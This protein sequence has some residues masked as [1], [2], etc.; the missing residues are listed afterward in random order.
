MRNYEKL[1]IAIIGAGSVSFCPSTVLDIFKSKEINTL[2]LE[3]ALMDI[4][5]EALDVSFDF[6]QKLRDQKNPQAKISATTNLKEALQDADFVVTAIEKD[7]YHYWSQDFHIPRRYGFRQIYGENG[8]PGGLFH[9]LRNLGPMLEIAHAMEEVCPDA[10]LLNYTNPEAKLVEIILKSTKIKA[11]GLCHGEWW[12]VWQVAHILGMKME[13]IETEACGLNHFACLTKIVDKKTGKDLY[14]LLKEK[15]KQ[16]PK[17]ANWDHDALSRLM[18]RVYGVW[19]YPGANHIGEYFA[20]S[21][22]FL[23]SA[24]MQFFYDP[25]TENPWDN[26]NNPLELVYTVDS[27]VNRD[28]ETD[29]AQK[30]AK[31]IFESAFTWNDT[32]ES[33]D[34]VQSSE[35]GVPIIE[36][37]VFNKTTKIGAVNVLNDGYAPNLPNGMAVEIPAIVDG[38]GIHPQ[39]TAKIPTALAAMIAT[40]GAVTELLHEAYNEKSRNK[41]LQAVLL[42]PTVSSYNNA[43][44]MINEMFELQKEVLPDLRWD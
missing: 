3:I 25:A 37:I 19:M 36:A 13:D 4:K 6:C 16:L 42:D 30:D 21:D 44:A 18:L 28:W 2:P 32:E 40:Q 9:T 43:V 24:A 14:P 39:K 12:G 33:N 1:K 22:G 7:R 38:D 17:L 29:M 11:V 15:E 34:V 23:A 5:K 8:G 35:Y 20:W 27:T 26:K 10:L 31:D 41:L